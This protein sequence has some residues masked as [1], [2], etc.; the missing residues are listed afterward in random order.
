MAINLSN[1]NISIQQFQA[2]ASGVINAGEVRL[3]SDHSID[4]ANNH[5][6]WFFNNDVHFTHAEVLAIKDAF[7]RALSESGVNAD[8]IANIRRDLGLA[9]I[10]EKDATLAQRSLRPLSRQQIRRI[11]DLHAQEINATVGAGTIRTEEQLHVRYTQQQRIN[12]AQTRRAA[13]AAL[14]QSRMVVFDRGISDVLSPGLV[15][16][17]RKS[18]PTI[19]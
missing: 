18:T 15:H 5:V 19:S 3:T 7:V 14:A 4:K 16:T 9:P 6:G 8:A 11:L 2:V 13:N 1:V 10:G 17:V 12:Y